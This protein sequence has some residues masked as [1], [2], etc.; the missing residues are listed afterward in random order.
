MAGTAAAF[1]ALF[2]GI[3]LALLAKSWPLLATKSLL[4]LL[5]SSTWRPL[6]NQFGF[7]PF[8][9]GTFWVTGVALI[10]SIPVSV[11]SAVYLAEYA[12]RRV[13]SVAKPL[14]DLLAGIPPVVYGLWGVLAVVPFVASVG[15]RTGHSTTGYSILAGGIVLAIMVFPI[16]ISVAEEVLRSV[17]QEA[18]EAS[19]ALGA[20]KWQT[21]KHVV[22][23]SV[24]PGIGAAIAL[25]FSRAFGETMAVLMVVGNVPKL[26]TSIFDPGYPLP[27]LIANN[28]GEMMSIPLYD[29]ALML[30]AFILLAVVLAFNIFTALVLRRI[31]RRLA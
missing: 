19:L 29:S 4:H 16:I 8:I 17:P 30:A 13:R 3:S 31:Q 7:R 25:G 12:G 20:T 6:A 1:L 22:F 26:P 9:L 15:N 24:A 21:V 11:L 18:R 5:T 14:L 10:L 23:R 2:V 28:Y 27:A